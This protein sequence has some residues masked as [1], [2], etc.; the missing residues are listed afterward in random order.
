[1]KCEVTAMCYASV[2]KAK[3]N[4]LFSTSCI[5]MCTLLDTINI[6]YLY[7]TDHSSET[8]VCKLATLSQSLPMIQGAGPFVAIEPATSVIRT[9][10]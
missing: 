4:Q 7:C 8:T 1:M 9:E 2:W 10:Y 6:W 3:L 5:D